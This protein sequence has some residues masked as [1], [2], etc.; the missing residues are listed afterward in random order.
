LDALF[1]AVH[2]LPEGV[3]ELVFID[4]QT[5]PPQFILKLSWDNKRP[6]T[7]DFSPEYRKACWGKIL[8]MVW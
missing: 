5:T 6:A 2:P 1:A 7:S 8:R 3:S 4:G